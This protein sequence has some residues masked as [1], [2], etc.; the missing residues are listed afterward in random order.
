MFSWQLF[1]QKEIEKFCSWT[2][3]TTSLSAHLLVT[4]Q[5]TQSLSYTL[6]NLISIVFSTKPFLRDFFL[7]QNFN[8]LSANLT[9][10]SNT[11]KQFADK[12]FE[13]V[14]PFCEIGAYRVKC[15]GETT[16][17][18]PSKTGFARIVCSSSIIISF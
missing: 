8:P 14:W 1:Y 11:L 2:T 4:I 18:R 12:L 5:S 10:W 3:E 6:F 7:K 16:Q 9:K 17:Y 15:G 13:G